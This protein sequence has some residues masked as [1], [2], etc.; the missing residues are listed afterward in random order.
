MNE[1]EPLPTPPAENESTTHKPRRSV[2][3]VIIGV[4]AGLAVVALGIGGAVIADSLDGSDDAIVVA[5]RDDSSNPSS[6]PSPMTS[7]VP[8]PTASPMPI[9]DDT[10]ISDS[11]FDAV[12]AAAIA[13]AGGSGTIE[14][15][16][17]EDDGAVAWE[18]DVRLSN[19]AKVEVELASDLSVLST[20][21][22]D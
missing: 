18:V 9:S 19:G 10:P 12:A 8:T 17:R 16:K 4:A 20:R 3:P 21:I 7:D 22:D 6:S 14:E 5:S 11:D 15:L 2:R 1:T 13:A